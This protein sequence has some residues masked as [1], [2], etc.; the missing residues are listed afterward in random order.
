M[1]GVVDLQKARR[2]ASIRRGFRN[3]RSRFHEDFDGTTRAQDLSDDTLVFLARA[4][5]EAAFYLYDLI[6]NVLHMGSG[7]EIRELSPADRMAVM[8]RYLFILDR[9]RFDVMRRLGWL[10]RYPGEDLPLVDYVTEYSRM[11]PGLQA[12]VP[13]LS[14]NH[15]DYGTFCRVSPFEKESVV[16]KLIPKALEVFSA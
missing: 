4:S 14:P 1:T 5:E 8:D 12:R 2:E 13:D 9:V 3:W 11:A 16:R 6:M 10:D 15:P 7:F